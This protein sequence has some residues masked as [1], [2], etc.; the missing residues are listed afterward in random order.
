MDDTGEASK[1]SL[2]LQNTC[3]DIGGGGGGGDEPSG[4]TTGT[5]TSEEAQVGGSDSE[6]TLDTVDSPSIQLDKS[7]SRP[8]SLATSSSHVL[9]EVPIEYSLHPSE[10]LKEI[11]DEVGIS[12]QKASTVQAQRRN[13]LQ[14][15]DDPSVLELSPTSVTQSISSIPSPTP[16]ER[17]LSPLENRNGACIQEV[18]NQ[19]SSNSKALSLVPV[20]KIQAPDGYNWR[21]YGQKQVKSPQGSRSYYR[22]TY[23]DCCAKK[24][25]CSDHTNR[26]TEIVYR[27]PHNHEPPRKV[28]TPKVN[29][30]AISS[31][32]RSQDSKVARLN[33]NADETVPSTSKKHV[34]ETIPI[35][36]TKQQDFSGL[37]D[38]A[39]T[40]V[41]REDCDEPTQKKRLKKCSSSLESLP[42]PGKKAKLVVHAGG[43]VGISS[44]G[45]RWRKYGQKMVK[46]NPHPRNY[47]RCTS[48][49]CPV[50]KHIERAVDNTTAV[51]ITYKGVHDHG[52]PVPKKRYGQPSAPLV[53]ATASASMTDSQTK[54]SEPT[55]QWSVDKEGALTGETLEHE[56]EKT[57]E[58]AKT[59]LSIGFEIKPC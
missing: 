23:S 11:K 2:Q 46:G 31:M 34:K 20:L 33:S 38:N 19:N 25:E 32:P 52:M 12:N 36:E 22:C 27:S 42:K 37:D 5:E 18:D 4:A 14:S 45:Y 43:D 48:A 6:E 53:A 9:S 56:G 29:K 15:A 16:G 21:K 7:A 30:L 10:F 35:S 47:Y 1:P 24:I 44:D 3:A 26:V 55:T 40:N 59:L 57:V 8:D 17:R 54:K 58:S 13:Q 41:K 28:N 49:G 50:R 39:E 51:I